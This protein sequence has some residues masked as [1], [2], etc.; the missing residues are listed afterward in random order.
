MLEA[1]IIGQKGERAA[2]SFLRRKGFVIREL[3]WRRGRYEVDIIA[4]RW[5]VLHFVEVKCRKA[6]GWSSPEEAYTPHK[7][8]ALSRAAAAYMGIHAFRGEHQF[9]LVAVETSDSEVSEIRYTER[10]MQQQW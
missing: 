6:G 10:V 3:N 7:F 1:A 9:D 8:A 5:G 4:E 2:V